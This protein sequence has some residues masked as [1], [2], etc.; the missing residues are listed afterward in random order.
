MEIQTDIDG[1]ERRFLF[2]TSLVPRFL[3]GEI[4]HPDCRIKDVEESPYYWWYK[5]LGLFT[6]AQVNALNSARKNIHIPLE[7]PAT[8]GIATQ[9]S[10]PAKL[11]FSEWWKLHAHLFAEPE[12]TAT[13]RIA[14]SEQ[15]IADLR[16]RNHANLVIPLDWPLS[17][18]IAL[19]KSV[20]K[21]EQEER[22]IEVVKELP[23]PNRSMALYRLSPKLKVP[24]LKHAYDVINI[25]E[26]SLLFDLDFNMK[27]NK[28]NSWIEIGLQAKVPASRD[29]GPGGLF[30][31]D[32]QKRKTLT[33][34]TAA[35]YKQALKYKQN[36]ITHQFP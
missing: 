8:P 33:D 18:I 27:M 25:V 20:I 9:L 35:I 1:Q 15:E 26:S 6:K 19:A 24:A 36:C 30:E 3:A 31:K 12:D 2:A 29:M 14:R 32:P 10:Y 22:N 28:N 7:P 21:Q 11:S 17:S 16:S 13:V 34:T 23:A 4:L 5:Y